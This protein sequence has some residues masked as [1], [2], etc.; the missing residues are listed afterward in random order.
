MQSK[1]VN[2]TKHT[3]ELKTLLVYSAALRFLWFWR[4]KKCESKFSFNR[5]NWHL[6][7]LNKLTGKVLF[8]NSLCNHLMVRGWLL[9]EKINPN[10]LFPQ[11]V[12]VISQISKYFL[13]FRPWSHSKLSQDLRSSVFGSFIIQ[14]S[15]S[16]LIKKLTW[17]EQAPSKPMTLWQAG[18]GKRSFCQGLFSLTGMAFFVIFR[19][20]IC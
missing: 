8:E 7:G 1:N 12:T 10:F 17:P 19:S 20:V 18:L 9:E 13:V 5:S 16:L 14:W 3:E 6:R 15:P 4:C 11:C 2:L